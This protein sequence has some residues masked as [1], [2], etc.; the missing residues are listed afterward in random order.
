L[1]RIAKRERK[2]IERESRK[3]NR[4]FDAFTHRLLGVG[5]LDLDP[6]LSPGG[7][8]SLGNGHA[9]PLL[10]AAMAEAASVVV[11][12]V[13][14][15]MSVEGDA[16]GVTRL[17]VGES[18]DSGKSLNV[19]ALM[20]ALGGLALAVNAQ[21][22]VLGTVDVAGKELGLTLFVEQSGSGG[23]DEGDDGAVVGE[24]G[25]V[26]DV[27]VTTGQGRVDADLRV[28]VERQLDG[29]GGLGNG[30]ASDGMSLDVVTDLAP[31]QEEA[32][33][34]E[35]DKDGQE[36]ANGS[37]DGAP[38]FL[39][40]SAG[41]PGTAELAPEGAPLTNDELDVRLVDGLGD[42]LVDDGLLLVDRVLGHE[43]SGGH[44]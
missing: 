35:K 19:F 14:A 4:L 29:G 2:E 10:Q 1:S 25:R 20:C 43:R 18:D 11:L 42:G 9:N 17:G 26:E 28:L 32:R 39:L 33:D 41:A 27:S 24:V 31:G 40:A 13:L 12:S 3:G 8:N 6:L 5:G 22:S 38:L 30:N 15:T 21:S 44:C 34:T 16:M 37:A 7:A 23:E 36:P